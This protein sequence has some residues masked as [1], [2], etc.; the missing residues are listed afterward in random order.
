MFN[1]AHIHPMIVHFP[2]AL[3]IFGFLSDLIFLFYKKEVCLSKTGFYLMVIGTLGA[4]TAYITGQF[5]T[6]EPAQ[7]EIV[8]VFTK[9]ETFALVTII[10]MLI[11]SLLR[12]YMVLMKRDETY[13]KWV[14]FIFCLLGT[15]SVSITGFLGGTMVYNYM[16]SI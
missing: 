1:P 9:H 11:G 10:I 15:I 2:I 13:L 6:N 3:I 7:G 16:M 12:I 4:V 8:S 5:F 14:V